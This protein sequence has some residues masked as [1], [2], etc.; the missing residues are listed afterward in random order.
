M[1][2]QVPWYSWEG[3]GKH[4][5]AASKLSHFSSCL[6]REQQQQPHFVGA[7]M[8]SE[9]T[10]NLCKVT[11]PVNDR[12]RVQSQVWSDSKEFAH[13]TLFH[14]FSEGSVHPATP[15]G[16]VWNRSSGIS[17]SHVLNTI[18]MAHQR[19]SAPEAHLEGREAINQCLKFENLI[20]RVGCLLITHHVLSAVWMPG[21]KPRS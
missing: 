18:H 10:R 16:S 6:V 3:K 15:P 14:C 2:F 5:L 8:S 19:S 4:E 9:N 20:L 1:E 13:S 11:L 21:K 12:T 7:K 17:R